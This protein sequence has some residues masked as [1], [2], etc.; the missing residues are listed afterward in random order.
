MLP[1]F[2]VYEADKGTLLCKCQECEGR[3]VLVRGLEVNPYNYC[4]YCGRQLYE[5]RYLKERDKVYGIN[6]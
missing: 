2:W 4:P 5:G 6:T 3:L 1:G